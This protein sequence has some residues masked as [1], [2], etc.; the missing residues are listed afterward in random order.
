MIKDL[1][2]SWLNEVVGYENPKPGLSR[3][4]FAIN[5]LE[6]VPNCKIITGINISNNSLVSIV[7]PPCF[8]NKT[9]K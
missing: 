6:L 2:T 5:H 8:S 4:N 9:T 3:V 7:V 1:T